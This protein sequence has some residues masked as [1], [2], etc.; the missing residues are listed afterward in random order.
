VKKLDKQRV[1]DFLVLVGVANDKPVEIFAFENGHFDKKIT[2]GEI[3]KT[4][5]RKYD[6]ILAGGQVVTNIT[7]DTTASEDA[8]TRQ[9]SLHLRSGTDISLIV[10]QLEKVE[11]DMLAFSKAL[12][13]ALK[14]Y[15]KDG[16]PV[17]GQKCPK[18]GAQMVR[19]EGCASCSAGCGYSKCG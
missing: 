3:V 14:K 15:I 6:L 13:R 5:S 12:A 2:T 19:L 18:C 8:L 17:N 1:F 4:A 7:K 9:V 11:D 16:T 10:E